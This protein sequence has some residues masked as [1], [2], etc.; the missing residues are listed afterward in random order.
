MTISRNLAVLGQYVS[1]SG[2][3]SQTVTLPTQTS[4][5]GKYLITNG[6]SATWD[7]VTNTFTGDVTG[8]GTNGTATLTLGTSGV[9]AG[10]YG[11]AANIPVIQVNSKGLVISASTTAITIPS[12][13]ITF[14]GDVTG[15]GTTGT[16]TTLTLSTSG[17]SAGTYGLATIVVDAKGRI[18][19]A[20]AG[21]SG[22]NTFTGDVTGT[23]TSGTAALTLSTSGVTA[24]TYGLATV[25]VDAKGRITSA[26]AGT[27]GS[28]GSN[29]FT[30]DV[31][32]TGT[33]GTAA[34]TLS[35]SGVTAGTYGLATVVV[36]AKGRITSATA[37]TAGSGSNVFT[38]DV[39]GTG[40]SGTA[41]LT[42]S[43]SGVTAGSYTNANI[44]IDS[45]GRVTSASNGVGGTGGTSGT[46]GNTY[47]RTSATTTAGQTTFSVT[48][49]PGLLVVY[50]NGILLNSADYTATSGSSVILS[51]A[52]VAGQIIEFIAYGASSTVSTVGLTGNF[53][54]LNNKPTTLAGYGITDATSTIYTRTKFT[55]TANQTIF[56]LTYTPG[57]IEVYA[58]G[59]LLDN[60]D[61][62]ASNGSSITLSTAA[63]AG[64]II[65]CIAFT[66]NSTGIKTGTYFR[67]SQV[68]TAGQTTILATYT[69]GF[70]QLYIN[71]VL[72]NGAD[73]T[74]TN[75]GSITLA[76]PC[77]LNDI[78]E[79]IAFS[80]TSTFT[81]DN[82]FSS[83]LLMGA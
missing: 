77:R 17:V 30:G 51:T 55:A 43:T 3:I 26:T 28:S 64:Q 16:S 58:N 7:F 78:I 45:K 11:S 83:F 2:I 21:S 5:S 71:G 37:G 59:V 4:N 56:S 67:S 14:I 13:S 10:T 79:I 25:V 62:T 70:L 66:S 44:T 27:A 6:T 47:T 34:L 41:A 60:T 19:S 63:K 54:D 65:E 76:K 57:L 61:Y 69:V 40:T 18:T 42:L 31:T 38:G 39:T 12:S 20:T 29:T 52:A 80:T 9:S 81:T 15:S 1:T 46:S 36:D 33:S 49:T 68:A 74:A 24:G 53:S 32:G 23:G 48:Y 75:G 72:L 8:T 82:I 35:T 50:I 73:Y 22:S